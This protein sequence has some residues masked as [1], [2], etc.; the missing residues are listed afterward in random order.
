MPFLLTRIRELAWL[1]HSFSL[2]ISLIACAIAISQKGICIWNP[3][4]YID[5]LTHSP[6]FRFCAVQGETDPPDLL[7]L[8]F[9]MY[10]TEDKG[11]ITLND[12]LELTEMIGASATTEELQEM[13]NEAN[14]VRT[15]DPDAYEITEAAFMKIMEKKVEIKG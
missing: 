7:H 8:A 1:S 5:S 3:T 15:G 4:D 13:M 2:S 11:T 12:L 14:G 10:D 6:C 9:Q